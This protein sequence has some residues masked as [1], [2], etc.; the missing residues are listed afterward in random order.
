MSLVELISSGK[1][2]MRR[3][4][5]QDLEEMKRVRIPQTKLYLLGLRLLNL[6]PV[7]YWTLD[8]TVILV[9]HEAAMSSSMLQAD[10]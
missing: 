1:V 10:R 4:Q 2:Q 3:W 5:K 7:S 8:K 9:N 6:H